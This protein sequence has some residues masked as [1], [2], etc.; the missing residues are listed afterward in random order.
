MNNNNMNNMNNMNTSA[1]TNLML[2]EQQQQQ[3]HQHKQKQ[4]QQQ[5]ISYCWHDFDKTSKEGFWDQQ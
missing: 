1:I 3:Q 2:I 5:Y 4:H